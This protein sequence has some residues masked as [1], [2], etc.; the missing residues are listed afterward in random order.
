MVVA[1]VQG[2]PEHRDLKTLPG[3]YVC[4]KR[5][6]HGEKLT[7][8]QFTSKMTMRT[9]GRGQAASMESVIDLFKEEVSLYDFAHCVVDHNLEDVDGRPLNFKNPNDVKL[10]EGRV[11]EEISTYIDELNNFERDEEAGNSQ[12]GSVH[13]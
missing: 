5:M 13:T 1:V 12:G 11:A 2:E 10:L 3:G 4:I 6:N 9:S 8:Q 7:R